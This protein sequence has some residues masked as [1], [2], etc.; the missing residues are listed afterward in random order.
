MWI[1]KHFRKIWDVEKDNF[2]MEHKEMKIDAC[3]Q[4][5]LKT[6]PEASD[7]TPTAF[8]N[9]RS[10]IGAISIKYKN[11]SKN[12]ASRETKPL[13]SEHE[14]KGYIRIKV[15]QPN[16][17]MFKQHYVWWQNTG[18]KPEPKKEMVIFLDGNNRNFDFNNLFLIT[19]E[20][21]GIF[22]NPYLHL[23][24]IKN[25]P[26]LTKINAMNAMLIVLMRKLGRKVGLVNE[27]TGAFKD[28][29]AQKAK[30]KRQHMTKEEREK[31]NRKKREYYQNLKQTNPEKY[32]DHMK[33]HYEYLK[34]YRK[35]NG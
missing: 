18:H 29:T 35:K 21:A 9:E 33:K 14:K 31:H 16:E 6:F 3:Y 15:G 12:H 20:A 23:G 24:T 5:F 27:S 19:R 30:E 17:W 13:Y 26:E 8:R 10:R 22:N 32:Q 34:T 7:V 25:Q 4:L 2:L 1:M 11:G 28:D